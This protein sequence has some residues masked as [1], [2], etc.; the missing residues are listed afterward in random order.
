MKA[1]IR[2][3]FPGGNTPYGFHSY[4]NYISPQKEAEKIFCIKGGPGVGKSTLM[5]EIC[6]HFIERNE[7]V[8]LFRCSADP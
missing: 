5:K 3:F 4:Y 6:Q 7:S 8:D 1:Q 2:E